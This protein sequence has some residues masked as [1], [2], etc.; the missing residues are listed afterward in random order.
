MLCLSSQRHETLISMKGSNTQCR[1]LNPLTECHWSSASFRILQDR[2]SEPSGPR[3]PAISSPRA[4]PWA[5]DL[6]AATIHSSEESRSTL[7]ASMVSRSDF[8]CFVTNFAL[9]RARLISTRELFRVHSFGA[10]RR[11]QRMATDRILRPGPMLD[12]WAIPPMPRPP[13]M[14]TCLGDPPMAGLRT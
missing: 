10:F 6:S 9:W 1:H 11:H 13:S 14:D 4:F 3:A 2:S 7:A 8:A 5:S 12:A